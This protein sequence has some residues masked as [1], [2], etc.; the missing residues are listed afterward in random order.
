MLNGLT[1]DNMVV[2]GPAYN[3]SQLRQNDVI[4]QI[5]GVPVTAENIH[6]SLLGSD[7]PGSTV[8]ITVKRGYTE[9]PRAA[10]KPDPL[11]F[12]KAGQGQPSGSLKDK[13]VRD[14]SSVQGGTTHS[15]V[16]VRM[17]TEIIADRRRMFEL[18]TIMKARRPLT[19]PT[20]PSPIDLALKS[21]RARARRCKH[22]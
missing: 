19:S 11:W 1:I 17:A 4:V 9:A 12:A 15:V 22:S 2:G 13:S 10:E 7:V 18:F 20:R 8:T 16:L 21:I 3:S 5:D 6:V 14:A